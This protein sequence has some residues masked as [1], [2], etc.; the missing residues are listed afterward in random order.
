MQCVK[1]VTIFPRNKRGEYIDEYKENGL[2]VPCGSCISCRIARRREW[3]VRMLHEMSYHENNVFI[4]LTYSDM[5]LPVNQGYEGKYGPSLPTLRKRDLQLFFKRLRKELS[6]GRKIRY[7][8]VGE[9]GDISMR[10]HYHGIIFGLGLN[11]NDKERIIKAWPYC[12]WNVDIIRNKSFGIVEPDSIG[13]VAGYID[14]KFT[15]PMA[16][17]IYNIPFREPVFRLMSQGIGLQYALDNKRHIEENKCIT[18]NGSPLSIPRYYLKKLDISIDDQKN[19]AVEKEIDVSAHHINLHHTD[20]ELYKALKPDEYLFY[21][22]SKVKSRLQ[23]EKNL[24]A[25]MKLKKSKI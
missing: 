6:D 7:Y 13:Y 12:D 5:Y 9:Y 16:E 10:P 11:Q 14:K 18:V 19:M 8:A 1:P 22:E 2:V 17:E 15:G 3:T 23:H 21:N 25:K 24:Y 4:T 20:I